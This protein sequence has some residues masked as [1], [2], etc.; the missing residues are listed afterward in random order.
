[1]SPF[2]G[3]VE[4]ILLT[5]V[6]LHRNGSEPDVDSESAAEL[7]DDASASAAEGSLSVVVVLDEELPPPQ[8]PIT[9]ARR[10]GGRSPQT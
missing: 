1:M 9:N 5:L 3:T 10:S 4:A 6:N 7:V 2:E 8:Q